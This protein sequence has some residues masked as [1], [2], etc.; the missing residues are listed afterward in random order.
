M[1]SDGMKIYM[2]QSLS[3]FSFNPL[4]NNNKNI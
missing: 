2:A 1:D 4:Q 3:A